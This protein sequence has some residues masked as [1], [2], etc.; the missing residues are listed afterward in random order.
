MPECLRLWAELSG[1]KVR[2]FRPFM[3]GWIVNGVYYV[4]QV[5]GN[6]HEER[7]ARK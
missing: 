2:E 7:N 1:N 4:Y 6:I 3:D 5:G